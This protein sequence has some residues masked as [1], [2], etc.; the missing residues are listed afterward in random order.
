MDEEG[1]HWGIG[2]DITYRY[3]GWVFLA[4]NATYNFFGNYWASVRFDLDGTKRLNGGQ[5]YSYDCA[6]TS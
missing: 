1:R 6:K 4:A 5:T 3:T 2:G